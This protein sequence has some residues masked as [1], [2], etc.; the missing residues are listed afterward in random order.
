APRALWHTGC[1]YLESRNCP[2]P[3]VV[4]AQVSQP[5]LFVNIAS[6]TAEP[7]HFGEVREYAMSRRFLVSLVI[8]SAFVLSGTA[9]ADVLHAMN[10][11]AASYL[12]PPGGVAAGVANATN[13]R[14]WEVQAR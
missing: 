9:N 10:F 12:E 3:W 1:I 7:T 4:I 13:V 11:T 2:S 5:R 8:L 6:R 14:I